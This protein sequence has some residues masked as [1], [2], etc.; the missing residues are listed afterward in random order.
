MPPLLLTKSERKQIAEI[1]KRRA[2]DIADFRHEA[3]R[4]YETLGSQVTHK[5]NIRVCAELPGSIDLALMREMD[6]L[7]ILA[8]KI[9]P[10]EPETED[11]LVEE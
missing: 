5:T 9:N 11:E 2:N 8:E 1:L 4:Q 3:T 10:P 7:R 6:R